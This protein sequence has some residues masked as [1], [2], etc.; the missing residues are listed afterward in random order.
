MRVDLYPYQQLILSAEMVMAAHVSVPSLDPN[1]CATFS[2][3]I[4][5]DLLRH[6]MGFKGIVIS[7]SLLMEGL[8]VSCSSIEEAA[9][10][11][12]NA[13]CDIL[14]LG[15]KQLI[16]QRLNFELTVKDVKRIHRFLVESVK[17]GE[18]AI[19]RV[20]ASVERILKLK[21]AYGLFDQAFPEEMEIAKYVNTEENRRL[22]AH[23][24]SLSVEMVQNSAEPIAW[25]ALKVA[26]VV[27]SVVKELIKKSTL[28]ALGREMF[29]ARY[30]WQ[31]PTEEEIL[32]CHDI[33]SQAEAVIICSYN[34]WQFPEQYQLIQSLIA[35]S[36]KAVVL[37]L[38]DPQDKMLFPEAHT[39][40]TTCSPTIFSLEVAVQKLKS[41]LVN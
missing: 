3:R 6:E 1:H 21:A 16:G 4:L 29:F 20:E 8:F 38:K 19:E 23:I 34:A 15:G 22:A 18:I 28:M 40:I 11:A 35:S 31:Q 12:F 37:A 30:A 24:A 26:V 9:L 7:D 27:P 2:N 10:R 41:N 39:V 36:R 33:A 25:D 13:G 32:K 14:L 5:E 17:N